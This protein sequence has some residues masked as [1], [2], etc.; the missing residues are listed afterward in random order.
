[1]G[2]IANIKK[3]RLTSYMINLGYLAGLL[4]AF[5]DN[6]KQ[7]IQT[8]ALIVIGLLEF[9]CMAWQ[10][11]ASWRQAVSA[12]RGEENEEVKINI[13]VLNIFKSFKPSMF[14]IV[15]YLFYSVMT[16]HYEI[17]QQADMTAHI[18]MFIYVPILYM[19][20]NYVLE[21]MLRLFTHLSSFSIILLF[22]QIIFAVVDVGLRQIFLK[23]A[24]S[25]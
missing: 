1:M 13:S 5:L 10:L 18:Q 4:I 14:L 19:I 2:S 3:D 11:C 20:V 8:I 23:D 17:V 24:L 22:I 16:M 15:I 7:L 9:A 6:K 21:M 12:S 25:F